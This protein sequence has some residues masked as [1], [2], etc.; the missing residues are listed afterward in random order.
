[1]VTARVPGKWY[2]DNIALVLGNFSLFHTPRLNAS[3]EYSIFN[4][5]NNNNKHGQIRPVNKIE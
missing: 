4:N 5:S 1:M 2:N 3:R